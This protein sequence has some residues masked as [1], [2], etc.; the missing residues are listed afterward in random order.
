MAGTARAPA[1]AQSDG[2][3]TSLAWLCLIVM[4]ALNLRPLLTSLSPLLPDIQSSTGMTYPAASLLTTLPV[5]MMGTVGLVSRQLQGIVQTRTW[6][7]TGLGAIGAACAYRFYAD[8]VAGLIL[9]SLVAGFGVAI[10]QALMPGII[11]HNYGKRTSSVIGMYSAALMGGGGLGAV[12]SPWTAQRLGDWHAGLAV[13]ALPAACALLWWRITRIPTPLLGA[14]Q[15]AHPRFYKTPRAWLLAIHFGWIN[16]GYTTMVAWLPAFYA[17]HHWTRQQTGTL[18][19]FMTAMQVVAALVLP[20]MAR[21]SVDRRPWL[22]SGLLA[23]FIGYT[24]MI[25]SPGHFAWLWVAT[26]GFGLGGTFS[27]CLI[28]ALDH[29]KQAQR[30]GELAAFVQGAGF[31]IAALPPFVTALLRDMTG[32]FHAAWSV[33][34]ASVAIL[35]IITL[36][37]DP[38]THQQAMGG[39]E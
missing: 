29:V 27:L 2:R 24:G 18:L 6:I 33:L 7:A 4:V 38:K 16:G 20:F 21:R 35:S 36:K 13:W 12:L 23:Q 10:I 28:L 19:G 1:V 31:M 39:V 3:T 9:S 22:M 15:L 5:L 11:K 17:E 8:T 32:S 34:A 14:R 30:A 37:F 26:L 25:L